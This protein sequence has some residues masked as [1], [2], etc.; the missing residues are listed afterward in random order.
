MRLAYCEP[1]ACSPSASR[2]DEDDARQLNNQNYTTPLASAG[3]VFRCRSPSADHP[4]VPY[5]HTFFDIA[6]LTTRFWAQQVSTV[7]GCLDA[8]S[9]PA[10]R[11]GPGVS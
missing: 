11:L 10:A 8:Q 7:F 1:S 4:I 5:R 2:A 6:H 9:G 3:G